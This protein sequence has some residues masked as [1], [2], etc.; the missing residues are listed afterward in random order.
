MENA[1]ISNFLKV[2]IDIFYNI[3]QA[4]WYSSSVEKRISKIC[5]RNFRNFKLRR[6]I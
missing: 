6:S 2:K 3:S 1:K 5:E 4:T